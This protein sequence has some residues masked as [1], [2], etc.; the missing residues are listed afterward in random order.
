[1][2]DGFEWRQP[3]W[4]ILGWLPVLIWLVRYWRRQVLQQTYADPHLWPW[5]QASSPA[6]FA[7]R[8]QTVFKRWMAKLFFALSPLRALAFAWI[9]LV[10]AL[11]EPRQLIWQAQTV[12]QPGKDVM[13]VLDLSPSMAAKDVYPSR[14]LQAKQFIESLAIALP[15]QDRLALVAFSGQAHLITPLT[16]DR[17]LFLH[18]LALMKPDLLPIRGSAVEYGVAYGL[19]RLQQTA[20]QTV[21]K[22]AA[23]VVISDGR[24]LASKMPPLPESEAHFATQYAALFDAT[25]SQTLVDQQVKSVVIGVGTVSQT[26]LADP[27][28]PTKPWR[29]GDQPVNAPLGASL[30]QKVSKTLQA[31]YLEMQTSQAFLQ[32]VSQSLRSP[33]SSLNT[34][35]QTWESYASVF[36]SLSLL[37][38]LLAFYPVVPRDK[39]RLKP[40]GEADE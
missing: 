18:F 15:E 22:S 28:A 6:Y 14:F 31:P 21:T 1:M 2:I 32:Q 4:L 23:M 8:D 24:S 20:E 30:L 13:V 27:Q 5:V 34:S 25:A 17:Q 7:Y 37:G 40:V 9:M 29:R 3:A 11:A 26:L 19:Q 10:I 12:T 16:H 33:P 38:L 39:N 35:Q 36:L